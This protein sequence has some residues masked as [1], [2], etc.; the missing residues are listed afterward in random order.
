MYNLIKRL[1]KRGWGGR[2]ISKAVG[3]IQDAKKNKTEENKFLEK[4]V[5]WILLITIIAG[6]FAV[7]AALIP[8]LLA[9]NGLILYFIIAV[10]GIFF[11]LLF[12]L[13]IRTIEH[14][15]RKHHLILAALIPLIAMGSGF[16]IT[17][18]S[19]ELVSKFGLGN[20]HLP[21]LVGLTYAVSFTLPYLISRFVLKIEYYAKE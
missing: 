20:P 7:S 14:L 10:L 3:I 4:R 16:L 21:I 18:T 19:N 1:E 8:I 15:E 2:E 5:Y 11:G 17:R 13:V 6:N 9:L 12:E